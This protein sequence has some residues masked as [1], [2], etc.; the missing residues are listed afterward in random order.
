MSTTLY[1]DNLATTTTHNELMDLF[2]AHGNVTEAN[3]TG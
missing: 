2:S 1:V 3:S